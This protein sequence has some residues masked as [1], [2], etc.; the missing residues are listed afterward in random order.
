MH[1]TLFQ[2]TSIV[3]MTEK[4]QPLSFEIKQKISD[5]DDGILG[6]R[7]DP[8]IAAK[9]GIPASTLST[10]LKF[11]GKIET[12]HAINQFEPARKQIRMGEN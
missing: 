6:K 11:K 8:A 12:T 2:I 7:G 4:K 3:Q 10:I 1:Q 9:Y 5:V